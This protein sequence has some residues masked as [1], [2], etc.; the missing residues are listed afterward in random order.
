MRYFK[1]TI[2]NSFRLHLT[3]EVLE[4]LL[5]IAVRKPLA[6]CDIEFIYTTI[7]PT[8][9]RAVV[10]LIKNIDLYDIEQFN[11]YTDRLRQHHHNQDD[12]R[13]TICSVHT[14]IYVTKI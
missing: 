2:P 6:M 12:Y 1:I 7:Y 11:E 4:N 9:R 3:E 5:L 8:R 10:S 14:V 13:I